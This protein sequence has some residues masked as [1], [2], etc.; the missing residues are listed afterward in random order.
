LKELIDKERGVP[1]EEREKG[2]SE[3]VKNSIV[4]IVATSFVAGLSAGWGVAEKVRVEPKS[5]EIAQLEKK[6]KELKEENRPLDTSRNPQFLELEAKNK[7]LS[8]SLEAKTQELEAENK[9]LEEARN[10]ISSLS[11]SLEAKT[12]E[13]EAENK[14]LEGA[15]N[16]ISSL[17]E[18]ARDMKSIQS[19]PDI[20]GERITQSGMLASS[21]R[22]SAPLKELKER[23][24]KY[25]E[26]YGRWNSTR[27]STLLAIR[28]MGPRFSNF[29]AYLNH[30]LSPKF[31]GLDHCLTSAYD[32]RIKTTSAERSRNALIKCG[33]LEFRNSVYSC[34]EEIIGG[35]FKLVNSERQG[36]DPMAKIDR[37]IKEKCKAN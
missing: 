27:Q 30:G 12:R 5:D 28:G 29:E 9:A 6:I 36:V 33:E 37:K 26:V 15:R 17:T 13:L 22:R 14:T 11:N 25:D 24:D 34:G 20:F 4:F 2:L 35:L 31:K 21:I 19:L 7:E 16:Q 8:N 18:K 10:Q 23:R 1:V 3:R 32:V